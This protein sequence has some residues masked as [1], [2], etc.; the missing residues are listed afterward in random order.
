MNKDDPVITYTSASASTATDTSYTISLD[1]L[2]DTT[3]AF[4]VDTSFVN[5][6]GSEYT[7][8]INER[9]QPSNWPTEYEL[10]D[11]LDKYPSL[12]IAYNKFIEVYNLVKDDYNNQQES[13][14]VFKVNG[15]TWKKKSNYG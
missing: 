15:K 13:N 7:F 3:D 8:N 5:D 12:K 9:R 10:N 14:N 1:N 2:I 4:T 11:M 6:T